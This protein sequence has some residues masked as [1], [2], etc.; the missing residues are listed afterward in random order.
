MLNGIVVSGINNIYNVKN[1][2]NIWTCRI[3][4]KV[5]DGIRKFHNP[6]AVGDSVVFIPYNL[7]EYEGWIV[8]R[9]DRKTSL[10]RWNKKRKSPQVLAAN[11][12]VQVCI[13]STDSPPFRPR[14]LDRLILM[15]EIGEMQAVIILNKIDL[16]ITEFIRNRI[17]NFKSIG[18][19]VLSCSAATGEGIDSIKE[20]LKGKF[21]VLT[22]QSGVG[23]SS[24]LN[25]L[26]GK[27]WAFVGLISKKYNRGSHT[28]NSS[29]M[30]F[31]DGEADGTIIIDTP[32]MR[33]LEIYG[34]EPDDLSFYFP[35]IKKYSPMCQYPSCSHI[36][37]P[38]CAVK[39]AVLE[40]SIHSDRYKSY[41]SVYNQLYKS[42]QDK[43]GRA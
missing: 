38:G 15:G 2:N 32:G 34:I 37:E 41:V 8:S 22:G 13:T 40:G 19:N 23:K 4:G 43:H 12:E 36:N 7:K 24:L 16:G 17:D 30:Y 33:E 39:K 21:S 9:E 35:D 31:L 42:S 14:F 3:K 25:G 5:F 28:T 29:N 10:E 6:I 1:D 18:Y 20:F 11:A 27:T 26:S